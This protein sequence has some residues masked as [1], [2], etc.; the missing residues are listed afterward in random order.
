MKNNL[1]LFSVCPEGSFRPRY[2]GSL[3]I[4]IIID[5]FLLAIYLFIKF[6]SRPPSRV[7]SCLQSSSSS[8]SPPSLSVE[9]QQ[10]RGSQQDVVVAKELVEGF[11]NARENEDVSLLFEF[12][13]LSVTLPSGLNILQ[14]V[15]GSVRPVC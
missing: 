2:M 15:S 10:K 5:L 6:S 8:L 13:N 9:M 3:I 11:K 7:F 12:D 14:G 4:C 1:Y